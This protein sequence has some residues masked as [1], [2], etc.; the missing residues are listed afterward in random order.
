MK[1]EPH[2]EKMKPSIQKKAHSAKNKVHFAFPSRSKP[3]CLVII[4]TCPFGSEFTLNEWTQS[5]V[6]AFCQCANRN[7]ISVAEPSVDNT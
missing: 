6:Y 3:S 1:K 4:D 7:M 2:S 5:L